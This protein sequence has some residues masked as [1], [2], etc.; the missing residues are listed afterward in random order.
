MEEGRWDK[1]F[2]FF[3]PVSAGREEEGAIACCEITSA[4]G[5]GGWSFD[6]VL[7]DPDVGKCSEH[8]T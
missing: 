4:P 7:G 6:D 3:S 1:G 8:V 2:G 5:C